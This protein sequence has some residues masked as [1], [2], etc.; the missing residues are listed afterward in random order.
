M[1]EIIATVFLGFW[2]LGLDLL[3]YQGRAHSHSVDCGR[4]RD[5][6]RLAPAAGCNR[7]EF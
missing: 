5:P 2:V 1:L 7:I 6:G 3:L 4:D